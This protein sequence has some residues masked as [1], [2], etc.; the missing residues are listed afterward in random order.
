MGIEQKE[1]IY[2]LSREQSLELIKKRPHLIGHDPIILAYDHYAHPTRKTCGYRGFRLNLGLIKQPEQALARLQE[3]LRFVA[4]NR[5][6]SH[7]Q[8]VVSRSFI[9]KDSME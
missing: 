2:V 7:L 6:A 9:A 5:D 4:I 8:T 1:A 3:F